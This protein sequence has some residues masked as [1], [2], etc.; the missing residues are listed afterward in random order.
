[1]C[2]TFYT[3]TLNKTLFAKNSDRSAN[4]PNLCLYYPAQEIDENRLCTY[5]N[6]GKVGPIHSIMLV[7]PSWMWGGEMGINDQGV[8]IGNE[9]VFTKSKGK[10]QAKLL[11]MDLLRLALE[12][13]A[14]A[15]Q[16]VEVIIKNIQ[17]FGQGGN[18]GFDKHFYYDNSY[19]IADGKEAYILE[20]AGK[21]WAL[22]QIPTYGAISNRLSLQRDYDKCSKPGI[23]FAKTYTEP[24]FTFFSKAKD[25][26]AC[27]IQELGTLE[28]DVFKAI[29]ILSSH[30]PADVNRLYEKGS[31]R[32]VCMH[33]S[34]LGDHTTGSMIVDFHE[35]FPTIW[36]TGSSSPCLA[37]FKPCFFGI[38]QPPVFVYPKE[39]LAYW[40]EQEYLKRAIFANLINRNEYL[41]KRDLLQEAFVEEEA[42]LIANN[43]TS[44]ELEDFMKSCYAQEQK[45]LQ[46]YQKEIQIIKNQDTKLPKIWAKKTKV[47][48]KNVFETDL[49]KRN[50]C[51]N[52]IVI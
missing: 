18:C 26:Q 2:D 20:T 10:K 1:M 38:V 23:D 17:E 36:L 15:M 29:K 28:T 30:H 25:R 7:Q 35:P 33:Q 22:K 11:G 4:E 39:S 21:D 13:S 48:G 24:L 46:E 16:A 6:V 44:Q 40:L 34:L 14:T 52:Q 31:V 9:A 12:L 51:N 37:L 32:S 19:L 47:L 8:V 43:P 5:L 45:W 41:Q 49:Y 50:H 42:K 27:V 3:K